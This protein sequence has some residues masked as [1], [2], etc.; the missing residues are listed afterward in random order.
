MGNEFGDGTDEISNPFETEA[1]ESNLVYSILELEAD[2]FLDLKNE[3]QDLYFKDPAT[4]EFRL[5]AEAYSQEANLLHREIFKKKRMRY[6]FTFVDTIDMEDNLRPIALKILRLFVRQMT[7]GN[8]IKGMGFQDIIY[9]LKTSDKYI[10]SA[11]TQLLE[12]D[13]IRFK[14]VKARRIYMV[15]PILY[16][17]G[18]HIGIYKAVKAY[19][20]MPKHMV[21]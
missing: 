21:E 5:V 2:R 20:E 17:K 12:N 3:Q 18:S 16:F 14:V 13:C 4:G 11:M 8:I 10:T 7:Y 9:L 1:T 19:K 15:N 6:F